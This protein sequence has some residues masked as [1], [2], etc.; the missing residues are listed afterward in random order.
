MHAVRQVVERR[1]RRAGARLELAGA[2]RLQ[3]RLGEGAADAHRLADRLHLRPQLLLGPR[4]LLEGEARELDDDVVERRLEA[5]RRRLRQVV[6]DLVERVA[7]RELGGDL[8]DRVAGR[9]ARERRGAG[10][11]R[12]HLDHAQLAGPALARELDVRAAGLDPDGADHAGRGV[13]ELLVGLVGERHLRRD[14]DG[15]AGVDAHRVEVLD[16]ADDDDVVLHVAHHLELELVPAD[17]RLLDEHLAHRAL[18][19]GP[20]QPVLE[21]RGRARDAAAVPAER[22]RRAQDHRE[23]RAPPA[24]P[25][26]R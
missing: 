1:P 6:G 14:G 25:R 8:G 4:E 16:R 21:L 19:E 26:A 10:D 13:A 17:E 11:A 12:V 7:D 22:E 9:L 15:V 20:L 5:R 18:G 24:A 2:H 3:E 23:A